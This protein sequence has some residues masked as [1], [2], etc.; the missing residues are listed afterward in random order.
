MTDG[1]H[2]GAL[3]A[4]TITQIVNVGSTSE[5][6]HRERAKSALR[7]HCYGPAVRSFVEALAASD[8]NDPELHY[9]IALALF[10]GVRPARH[11]RGRLDE[12]DTYLR[13]A[14]SRPE[15]L[16]VRALIQDDRTLSWRRTGTLPDPVRKAL[17]RVDA[18]RS[19]E[20][21]EHVPSPGSR[22]WALLRARNEEPA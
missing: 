6:A 22:V 16:A 3:H 8:G 1:I 9:Y 21:V 17:L 5:T 18:Q 15:A 10:E 14:G 11:S 19:G 12:I 4:H 13:G 2:N 20:I 7:A